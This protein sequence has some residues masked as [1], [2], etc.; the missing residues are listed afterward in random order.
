MISLDKKYHFWLLVISGCL[1]IA[2]TIFILNIP[3]Q[4]KQG[5]NGQKAIQIL[6]DMRRPFLEIKEAE[7]RLIETGNIKSA[8]SDFSKA[9]ESA[10]SR[11]FRYKQLA[12]YNPDLFRNVVQLSKVYEEWVITERYLFDYYHAISF[13]D[14][15]IANEGFL[16]TMSRLGDGEIPIHKDIDL[17]RNANRM[18]YIMAGLLFVYMIGLIFLQQQARARTFQILLRDRLSALKLAEEKSGELEAALLKAESASRAKSEFLANMSHELR[19]PLNSVIGF[20][21]V[22]TEG[23]AGSITDEQKEYTQYIWKSGKHLLSL[24]NDILDLSKI[25]AGKMELE[26]SEFD[27]KELIQGS[28]LMFKEKAIKHK[29]KFTSYIPDDMGVVTA[30]AVKIKQALLNLLGNA[31]KFTGDGGSVRV[32]ARRVKSEEPGDFDYI[33]IT[34]EDTGIGISPED[35]KILFQPFQQLESTLTKK[36]A[37][38]G[39]GL[40]ISKRIVELHGG[41]IWVE[42]EEGKGSRFIFIIPVRK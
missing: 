9:V 35:Q 34:V 20:S 11:L 5:E 21:E 18:L 2:G 7:S 3:S 28:M 4:I 40:S 12:Q 41:R 8:Y 38:M 17:G 23:L 22:L 32:A 39:L 10:D 25:E 14:M 16:N 13:Y 1:V 6:D 27:I 33:E 15:G 19:T 30:D 29:I 36:Y 37:G 24:I 26:L 42:S 31:F